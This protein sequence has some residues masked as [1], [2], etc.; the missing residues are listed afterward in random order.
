M[1]RLRAMAH[2]PTAAP[3]ASMSGAL[4]PMTNRQD[5]SDTSSPK[6]EAMTR[7]LTL[8]RFSV[9][10]ARPPKNSKLNRFFSTT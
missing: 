8:V 10:L 3:T 2:T 7:L 9:S 4:W 6:A 1:P 5:A